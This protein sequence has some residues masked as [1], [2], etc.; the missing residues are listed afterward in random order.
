MKWQLSH[1]KKRS[2]FLTSQFG[3][4]YQ[5]SCYQLFWKYAFIFLVYVIYKTEDW[6]LSN[7]STANNDNT[8]KENFKGWDTT[9]KAFARINIK[10]NIENKIRSRW[11]F[12]RLRV[13]PKIC[14]K[15]LLHFQRFQSL[16]L[17]GF[18]KNV[19]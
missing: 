5:F 11:K 10:K 19:S 17:F 1:P 13:E 9:T 4:R 6:W 2:E 15:V 7:P 14:V 16:P 8:Y 12:K 18:L 3:T